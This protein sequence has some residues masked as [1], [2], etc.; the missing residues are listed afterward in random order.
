MDNKFRLAKFERKLIQKIIHKQ[1]DIRYKNLGWSITVVSAI[2][3]A[4]LSD[5]VG[6]SAN[7][8]F[9]MTSLLISIFALFHFIHRS[10]FYKAVDRSLVV[11]D[12]MK[13]G[14]DNYDGPLIEAILRNKSLDPRVLKDK[15]FVAHY[16]L[17]FVVTVMVFNNLRY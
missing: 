7:I 8:Y 13:A 4:S 10:E 12:H 9:A 11:E 2:S 6:L 15:S 14:G 17:L 3:I 5:K 1:E 16:G